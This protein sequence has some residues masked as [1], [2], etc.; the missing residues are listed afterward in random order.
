MDLIQKISNALPDLLTEAGNIIL[1][2]HGV[3]G[4]ISS[5]A[6]VGNWVTVFDTRVQDFLIT[7]LTEQFPTATFIAEEKEN[8]AA[9]LQSE[10]CFVIDPIDGT[11]NFIK[12]YH[13]SCI[14]I[15]VF[16]YGEPIIGV[17]YDPYMG[18]VFMGIRGQGATCNGIPM[19]VSDT[20]LHDAVIAYG[21]APYYREE[22]ADTTFALSKELFMASADIRRC[23]SAALDLAYLAAGRN[24]GFYE[25]R[26]SPWDYAAAYVLVTE[27]GGII[28]RMD[29]TPLNFT[30][31][32]P[33]IA[34]NAVLYRDLLAITKK[35]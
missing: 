29:G 2:A 17:V 19:H 18:E 25:L 32:E 6:G 14:S 4:N 31:T 12:N 10:C 16:S 22:L 15:A 11:T 30:G 13:H 9:S 8:Q 34:G 27:A 33:V 26:L 24:D 3:S 28:S 23:G 35:Y 20:P 1:S 5:K 21:T 7:K